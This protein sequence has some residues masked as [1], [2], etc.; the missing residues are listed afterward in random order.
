LVKYLLEEPSVVH[1]RLATVHVTCYRPVDFLLDSALSQYR[2]SL[3]QRKV[4]R[5]RW[6]SRCSNLASEI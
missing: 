2:F 4:R 3:A 5:K 1:N 6:D